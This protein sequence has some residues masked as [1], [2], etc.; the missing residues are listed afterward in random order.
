MHET[1]L[2]DRTSGIGIQREKK[3]NE[4][5]EETSDSESLCSDEEEIISV[6]EDLFSKTSSN[7]RLPKTGSFDFFRQQ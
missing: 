1:K 3:K 5:L 6:A 2:E 4:L 7:V